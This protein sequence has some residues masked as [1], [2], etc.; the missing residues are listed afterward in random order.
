MG[1]MN[2]AN[3]FEHN[4]KHVIPIK[5]ADKLLIG[6]GAERTLPYI[7]GNDFVFKAKQDGV[8]ENYDEKSQIMVVKYKDDTYDAVDL[9]AGISKNSGGGFYISNTKITS[10]K[11]GDKF[12]AGEILA[13][14]NDYF[15]GEKQDTQYAIGNL[16]KIAVHS[17][18]Y[19]YEDASIATE[20]FCNEMTSYITM[21]KEKV[22]G[23]N[24]NIDF[25]VKKGDKIKTG[26]PLMVFEQ[27]YDEKEVNQMLEKIADEYQEKIT[28]LSK[29]SLTS[30]Y[31]GIVED[32]KIY[33][34]SDE[35]ELSP[36]LRKIIKDYKGTIKSK[37]NILNKYFKEDGCDI[38]L[39]PTEKV[40]TKD[41]KVK[42][43]TVG[44]GVLFE[45]YI[46]YEDELGIGDKI[47][48]YCALKSIV[49][50]V[51]PNE[52]APYS[53]YRPDENVDCI[54]S[55][56]SIAARMTASIYLAMFGNKVL[57]ELKNKV[58]E[59]YNS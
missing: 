57:I 43:I 40:E 55:H 16:T 59:I 6:N 46:K 30:K 32:I 45:F 33:Y 38:I 14:N 50:E 44:D 17:G 47:S 35:N 2:L 26:E 15:K 20:K 3:S 1:G 24:T 58:K 34:A 28:K 39:P 21:R 49:S 11:K 7:I 29:N 9:S 10:Y 36:S 13:K 25:I 4:A 48:Y 22:V 8:I 27:S 56:I 54:I 42:G 31:T 19:T 52:L 23:P 51:I 12:K 18:Y 53:Q 37:Q 41:G 5:K